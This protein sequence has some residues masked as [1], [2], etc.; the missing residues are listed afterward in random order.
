M[1]ENKNDNPLETQNDN[2]LENDKIEN[3]SN[4]KDYKKRFLYWYLNN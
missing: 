4:N 3:I 1:D 2:P